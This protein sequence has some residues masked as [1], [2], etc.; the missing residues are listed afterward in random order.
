MELAVGELAQVLGQSQPRVSR[1]I[2]ILCD[3]RLAERRREGSWIFLRQCVSKHSGRPLSAAIA[4]LLDAAEKEDEAFAARCAEDRR[5]LAAIREAREKNAAEYF[6]RHA[7][8]WDQIR[9]LLGPGS[10]VEAALVG[11]L[12]RDD[13]LG[14]LLDVGTGT[15]R[16]AA[17]LADRCFHLVGFDKSTEMLR[18]ARAKLQDLPVEKWELV[19]GNFNALPFEEDSFDTI[20]LHQV[21]HYAQDPLRV[22]REVARVCRSAGR[23]LIVDLAAHEREELR[24]R[25]AHVRLGFSDEQMLELLSESGFAPDPPITLPGEALT[26]KLWTASRA[27]ATKVPSKHQQAKGTTT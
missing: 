10:T 8:E 19:Q 14:R 22:L 11:S 2:A 5:H 1:H 12:G 26:T 7:G 23:V 6:A 13:R 16:I 27:A 3:S 17:L 24:K 4:G 21:L 15:G 9:A 20:T 25:H 18:L